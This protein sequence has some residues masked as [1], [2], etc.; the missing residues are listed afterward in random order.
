MATK[1]VLFISLL[2]VALFLFDC[3]LTPPKN[4]ETVNLL[5]SA[6][7]LTDEIVGLLNNF[8]VFNFLHADWIPQVGHFAI[9]KDNYFTF[10]QLPYKFQQE[11]ED[12]YIFYSYDNG[13]IIS[14]MDLYLLKD[15]KDNLI[16]SFDK[17]EWYALDGDPREYENFYPVVD[18]NF[19]KDETHIDYVFSWAVKPGLKPKLAV[20]KN[21]A[22]LGEVPLSPNMIISDN[23]N[24]TKQSD[25]VN[26]I[27]YLPKGT[28]I[29]VDVK[30]FSNFL[31]FQK[32]G[33]NSAKFYAVESTHLYKK[34]W[35]LSI[36]FDGNYWGDMLFSFNFDMQTTIKVNQDKKIEY[37]LSGYLFNKNLY[38]RQEKQGVTLPFNFNPYN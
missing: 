9:Y 37:A 33:S 15:K 1:R 30:I 8:S 16:Y 7:D 21:L 17:L 32:E 20:V 28:I 27:L 5:D 23:K 10:T 12:P 18:V 4:L 26:N 22:K 25:L 24:P 35:M 13:L 3:G 6:S 14:G 31:F 19:S 11:S 36:S 34:G 38:K 29:D 2:F